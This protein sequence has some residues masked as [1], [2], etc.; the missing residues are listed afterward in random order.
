[1][2]NR[3]EGTVVWIGTWK[4]IVLPAPHSDRRGEKTHLRGSSGEFRAYLDKIFDFRQI[5]SSATTLMLAAGTCQR[6]RLACHVRTE[7]VAE[8]AGHYSTVMVL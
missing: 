2:R 1:M 4:V 8:Q 6:R 7:K 3:R 5:L